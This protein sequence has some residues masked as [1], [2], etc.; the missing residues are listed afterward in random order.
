MCKHT[1]HVK[2]HIHFELPGVEEHRHRDT[3]PR[4]QQKVLYI[5]NCLIRD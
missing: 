5:S 2:T 1:W 4:F 3:Y